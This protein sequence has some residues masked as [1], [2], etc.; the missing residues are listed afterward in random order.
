M[1]P[2]WFFGALLFMSLVRPEGVMLSACLIGA[3]AFYLYRNEHEKIRVFLL[4]FVIVYFVPATI[5]FLWRWDFYGQFLPNT[6]YV[7]TDGQFYVN[8][9]L[10]LARYLRSTL[11]APIILA[12][13]IMISE[14][15][16]WWATLKS[17]DVLA[18]KVRAFSVAGI[19]FILILVILFSRTHLVMNY[20]ARFYTPLLPIIWICLAWFTHL[21]F[22][23]LVT[24]KT[25]KPLRF[26]VIKIFIVILVGVGFQPADDG[27]D[28]A[29]GPLLDGNP[30]GLFPGR[31]QFSRR[32]GAGALRFQ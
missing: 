28:F 23:S 10:D 30:R 6:F 32:R 26:K 11:V 12:I 3:T 15:D 5:Y 22:T 24:T 4:S 14:I 19:S 8:N 20:A 16:T 29:F 17:Q 2:V 7:K 13:A 21:G 18:K 25:E 9:L 27:G 1:R 31:R